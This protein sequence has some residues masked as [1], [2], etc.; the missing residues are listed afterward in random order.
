MKSDRALFKHSSRITVRNYE[1][2]WQGI[3]HNAIYLC[4]FE[5]GR[6][7]YL[8]NLGIMV[9]IGSI[10]TDFRIVVVRNE[11]DY[12]TPARFGEELQVLTRIS[13]IRNSSFT[14]EGILE[15]AAT[16]R[17]VAE[18]VSVHALLDPSGCSSVP[19]DD[20]FR[21]RVRDFEGP[22]VEIPSPE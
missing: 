19:L 5:V 17:R 21:K 20:A 4:Y 7:S 6:I 13:R 12:R 9:N 16:R 1:I 2:D 15:D 14:F 22:N 11:I 3:V 10:Q 18:N 8:E